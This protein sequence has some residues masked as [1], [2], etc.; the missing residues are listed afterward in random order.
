[1]RG[2]QQWG[3]SKVTLADCD[4]HWTLASH[5][6]LG[7]WVPA[8]AALALDRKYLSGHSQNRTPAPRVV[9]SSC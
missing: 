7:H 6:P 1:M 4:S 9:L 8:V 2:S 3:R 5:E